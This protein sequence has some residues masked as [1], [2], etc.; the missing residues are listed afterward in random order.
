VDNRGWFPIVIHES[1]AGAW[2]RNIKVDRQTVLAYNAVFAC[3][4]LI[5][6]DI[7]KMPIR[8]MGQDSNGIWKEN[9]NATGASIL[10]RP[11]TFQNRIQFYE[12]WL[13]SKLAWG[14][15]Y[16]LK[17]R[18]SANGILEFRIL[19]PNKVMPL[20]S[21]DGEVFYQISPDNIAGVEKQI[22]VPAREIIHDRFNCLYHP[23][24]GLSP[25]Y[26]CGLSAMQ[27]YYIQKNSAA[28]FKNGGKP[29]GVIRVPGT[30]DPEKARE[31]KAAWETS[32]GGENS[33]KTALISG[34]ADYVPISMS[35]VDAQT[36]EQLKMTA[37]IVC[38]VF[39][40]AAYKVGAGTM[41]TQNNI[42]ALELQYYSQCLQTHIESIELLMSEA[43]DL[44][45]NS[46]VKF[47]VD[48]LLRMDTQG[49]YAT[50]KTAVGSAVMSPN[51]ARK[52]ENLPPVPGGENPYLQQ[53]N[54][55]LEALSRR[56]AKSDPFTNTSNT[57]APVETGQD[58]DAAEEN[59][60]KA[61]SDH[62][63]FAVKAM[64]K[65]LT[66]HE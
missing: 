6:N 30:I 37:E 66:T 22:I 18:D 11:N 28:F 45:V 53:Q 61:L 44:D 12:C 7:A 65:G 57:P 47:D 63:L 38:S 25:I 17:I 24:I 23:L 8:L 9:K 58:P 60:N 14:N 52:K 64:M 46:G 50:Y 1:F 16:I 43:F 54:Y 27:G 42:E 10:R 5:A 59:A 40:V 36:V 39:H 31:I 51:E 62:E 19:D 13:N 48:V 15:T 2:Q 32:Y 20:V 33:G 26:A 3:I 35:A 21:D 49:R 34:G 56:D 41:P 29:S 4:S 55:S